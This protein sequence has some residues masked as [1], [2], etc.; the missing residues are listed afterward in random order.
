MQK[1]SST[2]VMSASVGFLAF[3]VRTQV[4]RMLFITCY[5]GTRLL[6]DAFL[7]KLAAMSLH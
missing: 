1:R 5:R 2:R 6:G 3:L 7:G 4:D